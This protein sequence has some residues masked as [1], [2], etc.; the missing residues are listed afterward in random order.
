M[1]TRSVTVHDAAG[2]AVAADLLICAKCGND[3]FV[4]YAVRGTHSHLQ[5]LE[6]DEVYCD[7]SCGGAVIQTTPNGE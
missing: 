6:C 3:T 5:C 7:G 4:I 2:Q 1:K